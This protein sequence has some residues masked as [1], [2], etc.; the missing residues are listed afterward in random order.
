MFKKVEKNYI[1]DGL[2]NLRDIE[3]LED[4][5]KEQLHSVN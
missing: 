2:A 4:F 3:I 1:N 5:F